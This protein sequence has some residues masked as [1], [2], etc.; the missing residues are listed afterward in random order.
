MR[1][2]KN[3]KNK[4]REWTRVGVDAPVEVDARRYRDPKLHTGQQEVVLTTIAKETRKTR[5]KEKAVTTIQREM[6][7]S[8]IERAEAH[9]IRYLSPSLCS[10]HPH[11][12]RKEKNKKKATVMADSCSNLKSALKDFSLLSSLPTARFQQYKHID[13]NI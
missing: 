9:S 8:E 11:H 6:K 3:E 1:Q 13:I 4:K 7:A 12:K 10:T 5:K 2:I